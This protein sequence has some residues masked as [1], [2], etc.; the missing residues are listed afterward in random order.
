MKPD[1]PALD[2]DTVQASFVTTADDHVVDLAIGAGIQGE[3]RGRS[4]NQ[5][6]IMDAEIGDLKRMFSHISLIEVWALTYVFSVLSHW[7]T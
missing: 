4:V 5:G 1:V 6:Q 2:V 7:Q 3:M